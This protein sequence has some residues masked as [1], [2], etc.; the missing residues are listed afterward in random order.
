MKRDI[1]LI[2]KILFEIEQNESDNDIQNLQINTYSDV[3][4]TY[5]VY[6][7][8]KGGLI[9]ATVLFGGGTV[10]PTGYSIRLLT[11]EGHDFLDACRDEGVWIKA[12]KKLKSLGGEVPFEVFKTV[13]IE[14]MKKQVMGS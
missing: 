3:E 5:H 10:K 11:W 12:K 9:D 7:L 13:L 4:I 2:R 8:K 14:I 1:D 6:L